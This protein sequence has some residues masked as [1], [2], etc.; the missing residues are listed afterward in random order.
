M[1]DCYKTP[2]EETCFD[3]RGAWNDYRSDDG[4]SILGGRS[5]RSYVTDE[6]EKFLLDKRGLDSVD[7][8]YYDDAD[9][10][11]TYLAEKHDEEYECREIH[12]CC[13]GEW[14]L[15]VTPKRMSSCIPYIEQEFFN[16]CDEWHCVPESGNM[17][18]SFYCW[19]YP[20]DEED[21]INQ[22]RNICCDDVSLHY[23]RTVLVWS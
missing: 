23:P 21:D 19:T 14:A 22:L 6:A 13:Q 17:D 10:L 18:D 12:G 16:I 15:I 1:Y 9:A 20:F 8:A 3:F 2:N 5:F 4:Y 11:T 7:E